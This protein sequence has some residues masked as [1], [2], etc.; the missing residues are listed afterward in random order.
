MYKIRRCSQ[1]I[2]T[3]RILLQQGNG[4]TQLRRARAKNPPSTVNTN[5]LAPRCARRRMQSSPPLRRTK[6]AQWKSNGP[7]GA[8]ELQTPSSQTP[9]ECPQPES[10]RKN[11]HRQWSQKHGGETSKQRCTRR[12][13]RIRGFGRRGCGRRGSPGGFTVIAGNCCFPQ[14]HVTRLRTQ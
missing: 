3:I 12:S 2:G 8:G 1:R 9:Q 7:S 11:K 14:V 6:N 5:R 4:K 13:W 10:V